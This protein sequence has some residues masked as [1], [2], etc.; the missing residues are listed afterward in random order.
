MQRIAEILEEDTSKEL[1]PTDLTSSQIAWL[2]KPGKKP[3]KPEKLRPVGVI[4]PE[5]KI[6]A[7]H[8]RKLIKDRLRQSVNNV[9][10]FDL[11]RTEE[12]KKQ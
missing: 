4:A 1:L 12:P 6:L 11:F 5:G 7:G 8:V 9:P 3:D 2:P 10:Q